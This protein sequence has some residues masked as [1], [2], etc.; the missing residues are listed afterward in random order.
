MGFPAIPGT[1]LPDNMINALPIYDFGPAFRYNDLSGAISTQPPAIR[2]TVPMLVPKTD[3]DG[4]EV[5]GVRFRFAPGAARN[6]SGL[7]R[8]RVRI[9]QGSRLR[10]LGWLHPVRENQANS[11][12]RPA[13]RGRLWKNATELTSGMSRRSVK[14]QNGSCSNVFCCRTTRS[15]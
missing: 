6:V 12:S 2:G 10:V 13:I 9:L 4:N 8:D 7:E 15:G 5:G 1:P 14:R 11:G 3:A